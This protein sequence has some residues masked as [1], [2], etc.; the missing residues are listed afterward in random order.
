M[1][2]ATHLMCDGAALDK[3]FNQTGCTKTRARPAICNGVIGSTWGELEFAVGHHT[4]ATGA[5]DAAELPRTGISGPLAREDHF[6]PRSDGESRGTH[7]PGNT[8]R[9]HHTSLRFDYIPC[10]SSCESMRTLD[11]TKRCARH[12]PWLIAEHISLHAYRGPRGGKDDF[13][14]GI[15]TSSGRRPTASSYQP[16]VLA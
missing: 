6:K 4:R 16:L 2:P 3:Y 8:R 1:E 9:G 7:F 11:R 10:D 12:A 14:A 15:R 5:P 13:F